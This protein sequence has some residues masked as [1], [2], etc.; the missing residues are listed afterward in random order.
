MNALDD[1]FLGLDEVFEACQSSTILRASAEL[2]QLRADAA[3]LQR[4]RELVTPLN[5]QSVEQTIVALLHDE[6]SVEVYKHELKNALERISE[7]EFDNDRLRQ[8][9]Q[10]AL[11]VLSTDGMSVSEWVDRTRR[12]ERLR[13]EWQAEANKL[14]NEN[15]R[16]LK[17]Y[18]ELANDVG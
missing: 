5:G 18:Q 12:A 6:S 11:S 10:N 15:E 17:R 16:L 1:I 2:A 3:E 14:R 7:L 9:R 13:D 4:I 8:D